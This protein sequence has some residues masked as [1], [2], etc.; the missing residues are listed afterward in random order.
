MIDNKVYLLARVRFAV[1]KREFEQIQTKTMKQI[2]AVKAFGQL[3]GMIP[4]LRRRMCVFSF[5]IAIV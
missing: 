1:V 2:E 3:F 5:N 4:A